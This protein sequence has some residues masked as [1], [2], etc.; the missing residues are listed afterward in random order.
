MF[1]IFVKLYIAVSLPIVNILFT[2][3]RSSFLTALSD[4]VFI[5]I[6][7]FSL[8]RWLS[9]GMFHLMRRARGEGGMC[10]IGSK[11]GR[12]GIGGVAGVGCERRTI[13]TDS[14][15]VDSLSLYLCW[16]F[17][18]HCGKRGRTHFG[19]RPQVPRTQK[20]TCSTT[21]SC[22]ANVVQIVQSFFFVF[23]NVST[24]N[25]FILTCVLDF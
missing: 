13:A 12:V 22:F 2:A 20:S 14:Q 9:P 6:C 24:K 25:H 15:S 10:H 8:R 19:L 11:R 17:L 1:D 18:L 5:S 16:G 3:N 23:C 4:W 21:V 7:F